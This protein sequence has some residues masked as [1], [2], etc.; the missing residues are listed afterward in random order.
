[1]IQYLGVMGYP[2]D[3][4]SDFNG[5]NIGRLVCATINLIVIDFK[6]VTGRE[7]I[8]L[9][10]EK[11]LVSIDRETDDM[12]KFVEVNRVSLGE[13]R[14]ILI[15]KAMRYSLGQT[16]KQCLLAMKDLCDRNNGG[17]VYGFVTTGTHWQMIRYDGKSFVATESFMVFFRTM[18]TDKKRWMKDGSAL[19]DCMYTAL[20]KGGIVKK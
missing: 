19:V 8:R 18:R 15:V 13:G 16:V 17:D 3:T 11:E 7:S 10:S 5:A 9:L 1:M 2:T 12:E 20:S 6:R 4:N 14:F